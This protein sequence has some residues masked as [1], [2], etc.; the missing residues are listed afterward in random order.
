MTLAAQADVIVRVERRPGHYV[1]AG[2]PLVLVWPAERADDRLA[3][4]IAAAFVV[5]TQRTPAQDV[6]FSVNQLVE[7]ALRALSPGVND[8]FTAIDLRRPSGVGAV[9]PGPAGAAIPLPARR[10]RQASPGGVVD[11]LR[12]VRG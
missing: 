5:G 12:G 6:E 4:R 11:E 7:I 2:S 10:A 8:P 9:S 1:I 3:T